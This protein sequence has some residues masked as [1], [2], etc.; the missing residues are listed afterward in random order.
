MTLFLSCFMLSIDQGKNAIDFSRDVLSATV[1][2]NPIPKRPLPAIFEE[3]HG[4]FTTLHTYPS[5]LLRGCIGIPEPVMRLKEALIE[6]AQSVTRDPRFPM[7][8]SSELDHI[9]V[10][11][12]ILTKPEI[13]DA[14]KE[15]LLENI[16]VGRDGL[17]IEQGFFKG[18]LL[19]QV[20]V[21]QNWDKKTFVEHTCLKAGLPSDAWMDEKTIIKKFTGQIFSEEKPNGSVKEKTFDES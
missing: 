6:S 7:L 1:N 9:I 11:I 8:K 20:P 4:V 14:K 10:E 2:N 3:F 12:T 5:H 17:I 15:D 16:V 18:L 21:E 13:I 19:P